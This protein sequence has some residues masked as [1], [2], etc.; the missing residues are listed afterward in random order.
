[1][2][3][4]QLIIKAL[5]ILTNQSSGSDVF[6]TDNALSLNETLN[7]GAF[8]NGECLFTLIKLNFKFGTVVGYVVAGLQNFSMAKMAIDAPN[9]SL[10]YLMLSES[11]SIILKQGYNG[12]STTP[13]VKFCIYTFKHNTYR[14]TNFSIIYRFNMSE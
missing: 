1:M 6:L 10:R 5:A 9:Q 12:R 13:K 4:V 7:K 3:Y 2:N 14:D 8:H 11:W